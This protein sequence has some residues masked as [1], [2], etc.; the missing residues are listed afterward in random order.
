MEID[1]PSHCIAVWIEGDNIMVRLPDRQL[2]TMQSPI[3]LM[4]LAH[5]ACQIQRRPDDGWHQ[6]RPG[7]V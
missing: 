4:N 2:L 6:S 1:A 3:Q 5:A 7:S